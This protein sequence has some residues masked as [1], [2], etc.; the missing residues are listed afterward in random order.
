MIPNACYFKYDHTMIDDDL[1]AVAKYFDVDGNLLDTIIQKDVGHNVERGE[2]KLDPRYVNKSRP[3]E[4]LI[5]N[6]LKMGI[7]VSFKN[8]SGRIFFAGYPREKEYHTLEIVLN[9]FKDKID[10]EWCT[11]YKKYIKFKVSQNVYESCVIF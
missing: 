4:I 1:R 2:D 5:Y 6:S 9:K 10:Y 11:R 3:T 8:K 7:T